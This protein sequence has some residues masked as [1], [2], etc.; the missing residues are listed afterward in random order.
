VRLIG[1]QPGIIFSVTR[2][3]AA[4]STAGLRRL[5]AAWFGAESGF[6]KQCRNGGVPLRL[7]QRGQGIEDLSGAP[8]FSSICATCCVRIPGEVGH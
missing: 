5:R 8:S 6:E 2:L 1:P 7:P 4:A 3:I